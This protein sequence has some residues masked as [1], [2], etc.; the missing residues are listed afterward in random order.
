MAT[1]LTSISSPADA[2]NN[3]LVRMGFRL[4]V[5]S[6]L[7]GSDHA[8]TILQVY[9]QT[10]DELLASF[11]YDFAERTAPLTLLKSAPLA[12]YFPPTVWNPATNPPL[13]FLY[14]YAW[15]ASA[16]KL[17]NIK[18]TPLW[19]VNWDPQPTRWTEYNDNYITPAQRTIVT[20]VPDAIAVFTGR[21]VDPT[22][23]SVTFADALAARLSV[24]LGPALV[25]LDSSRLT[26]PQDNREES[27]ATTE[28][29]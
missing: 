24:L 21:V 23:W 1:I 25:G 19:A 6:L 27:V 8:S 13:G 26:V 17:R 12:G 18:Y 20:N 22:T 28:Q 7:D 2:A 29:R 4:R 15:P 16:L 14:E 3:A 9:G 10:R 5:G 11:D